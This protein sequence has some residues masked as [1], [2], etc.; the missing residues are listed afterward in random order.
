MPRSLERLLTSLRMFSEYAT[1]GHV[2]YKKQPDRRLT[3][4]EEFLAAMTSQEQHR[5]LAG[6]RPSTLRGY[7][8]HLPSFLGFLQNTGVKRLS[9]IEPQHISDFM[10]TQSHRTP[11]TISGVASIIRTF[12]RF[13]YQRNIVDM[14]LSGSVLHVDVAPIS[15]SQQSGAK[16][17]SK[18]CWSR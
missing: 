6:D 4:P 18:G 2:R 5:V 14:D 10:I 1:Q 3:L 15:R 17:K 8:Q 9:D 7:R 13:L 12:M 11:N 16:M